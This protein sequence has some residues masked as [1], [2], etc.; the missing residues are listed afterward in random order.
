VYLVERDRC[1]A[2]LADS[3]AASGAVAGGFAMKLRKFCWITALTAI[4][5]AVAFVILRGWRQG[6]VA[7]LQ[8]PGLC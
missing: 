1:R 5:L 6:G 3:G 7:L 4:G 8:L 2:E